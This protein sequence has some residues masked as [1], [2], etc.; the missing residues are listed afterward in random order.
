[1]PKLALIIL[2]LCMPSVGVIVFAIRRYRAAT[3][4]ERQASIDAEAERRFAQMDDRSL[5]ALIA[6]EGY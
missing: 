5:E 4:R 6:A 1:M 2:F 3:A